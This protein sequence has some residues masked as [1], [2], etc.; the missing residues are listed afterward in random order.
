MMRTGNLILLLA[1]SLL[2]ISITDV[3][4]QTPEGAAWIDTHGY[5]GCVKLFNEH[6]TVILE[7]NCGGRVLVYALDGYNVLYVDPAQNGWVYTPGGER[8]GPCAGR[9]DIGPERTG[10]PRAQLWLGRWTAEIT[11]PRS[12]RMTSVADESSGVRLIRAFT[13]DRSTSHLSC[14]QTIENISDETKQYFHWSRTFAEGGGICVVPI[15]QGSRFPEGYIYYEPA[16]SPKYMNFRPE[17]HPGTRVRDG[18]L[19]IVD[20]PPFPKFGLDTA[21]GWIAYLTKTGRLFIKKFPV[22]PERVY[23]EM[24]SLTVSIWYVADRCEIEPIGPRETLKP[25]G[26]ASFTEDWWLEPY[27]YPDNR[28]VDLEKLGK[29][30]EDKTR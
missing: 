19:E 29:F 24:A 6:T 21:A 12:A 8:I 5:T 17:E 1:F 16:R 15:T 4:A 26:K 7:P 11:G 9:F 13:L 2:L 18:C 23:G 30:V 3:S 22:Y 25:G 20:T 10:P 28:R 27:E 14:T